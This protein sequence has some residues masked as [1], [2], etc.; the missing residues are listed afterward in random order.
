MLEHSKQFEDGR[1]RCGWP[2]GDALYTEYHD[3]EWGVPLRGDDAMFERVALEGFQAG[4][5]WITILKR[6]EGF[7]RAFHNFELDQVVEMTDD[8]MNA[9]MFDSGIIRN[10][11]KIEATVKNARLALELP[12]GLSDFVWQFAPERGKHSTPTTDFYWHTESDESRA[13]SAALK[14]AGFSF[15]GPTT[16]Y[17]LMQ[18]TG[19]IND[20]TPECYRRAELA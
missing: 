18:A 14:K 13:L 16:M 10:R 8:E 6:R 3:T 12:G 1:I 2:H 15:V 5:S 11:S 4:L 17:A 19:M 7:R 9:L 20:H